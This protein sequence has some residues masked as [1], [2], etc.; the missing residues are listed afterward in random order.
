MEGG[1][2]LDRT[3]RKEDWPSVES[4]W[5]IELISTLCLFSLFFP[6]I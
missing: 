5:E 2:Q 1:G 3:A 6:E 4:A